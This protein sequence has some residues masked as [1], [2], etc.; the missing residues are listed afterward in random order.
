LGELYEAKYRGTI[1][2]KELQIPG[3]QSLNQRIKLEFFGDM[4]ADG[5]KI[6]TENAYVMVEV[7]VDKPLSPEVVEIKP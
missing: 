5:V 6:E 7:S 1:D 2:L 3:G 4:P